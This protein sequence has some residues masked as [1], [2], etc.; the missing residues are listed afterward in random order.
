[1]KL[2][3][4]LKYCIENLKKSGIDNEVYEAGLLIKHFLSES[5]PLRYDDTDVSDEQSHLILSRCAERAAGMPMAYILGYRDFYKDRFLVG[6]GALIP[7]PDTEHLLYAA[8]E[9]KK[10]GF[11]PSSILDI[12]SGSGALILSA[13]HVFHGSALYALDTDTRWLR[14][15]AEHLDVTHL[16]I[17]QADVFHWQPERSFDLIFSNPP[18]LNDD[19]TLPEYEP[20]RAFY[21]GKDGLDFYRVIVR[22]LQ[23]WLNPGGVLILEIDYKWHDVR[24]LFFKAG[25]DNIQVKKDYNALERVMIVQK[26]PKI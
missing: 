1:M 12:G 18:Y 11:N 26:M 2:S 25:F 14:K 10:H 17:I 3:E 20:R 21:G 24:E 19:D 23:N 4:I 13:R 16:E 5:Y 8:A 15:N 7:R 22:N 6:E 9:L